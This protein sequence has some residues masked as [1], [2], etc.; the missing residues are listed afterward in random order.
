MQTNTKQYNELAFLNFFKFIAAFSVFLQHVGSITQKGTQLINSSAFLTFSKVALCPVMFFFMI[1]GFLFHRFYSGRIKDGTLS[2]KDFIVSRM[3]KIYPLM[4]ITTISL[5]VFSFICKY[6][7]NLTS[8]WGSTRFIDLLLGCLIGG[9]S[10]FT[11]TFGKING[12][13]WYIT[14]LILCYIISLLITKTSKSKFVYLIPI[15]LGFGMYFYGQDLPFFNKLVGVGLINYFAGFYID[16]LFTCLKNNK[17]LNIS[18][19]CVSIIFLFVFLFFYFYFY[20]GKKEQSLLDYSSCGIVNVLFW[21]PLMIIFRN[22]RLFNVAC[23]LRP[24]KYVLNL[25]YDFYMWHIF[26]LSV[27]WAIINYN[28]FYSIDG[29]SIFLLALGASMLFAVISNLCISKPLN[30]LFKKCRA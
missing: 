27:V 16:D 19:I 15:A 24:V 30:Y 23:E 13:L 7:L 6:A 21:I 5:F 12:A 2:V 17:K 29:V 9:D 3:K 8:V 25:N 26:A 4:I 1:S 28:K 11:G 22:L 10:I 20:V 18:L 14:I